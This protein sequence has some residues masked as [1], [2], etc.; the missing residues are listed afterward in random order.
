MN[1]AILT[2]LHFLFYM[3]AKKKTHSKLLDRGSLLFLVLSFVREK[4]IRLLEK[5]DQ[6]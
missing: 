2:K 5:M 4:E 1:R 6:A 3:L